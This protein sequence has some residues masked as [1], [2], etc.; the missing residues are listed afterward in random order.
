MFSNPND[1][2]MEV[3]GD[4]QVLGTIPPKGS[5]PV[6]IGGQKSLVL[7]IGTSSSAPASTIPNENPS[8]TVSV[9]V[10]MGGGISVRSLMGKS[11]FKVSISD[12]VPQ[13]VSVGV[14]SG[15]ATISKTSDNVYYVNLNKVFA[16]EDAYDRWREG[17]SKP[18]NLSIGI[19][20]KDINGYSRTFNQSVTF[21]EW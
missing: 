15:P 17:K 20:V 19:T 16:N 9:N 5:R 12:D 14:T 2:P 4:G 11:I 18:Y 3:V 6:K 7:R 13:S 21:G 10:P 1:Q 8:V